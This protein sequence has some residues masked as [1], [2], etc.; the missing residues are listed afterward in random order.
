V[1]GDGDSKLKII[2]IDTGDIQSVS[3]GR[4]HR[5]DEMA[6]EPTTDILVA[7]NDREGGSANFLT[8]FKAHPLSIVGKIPCPQWVG[9]IEQPVVIGGR[10]YVAFPG[11]TANPKGE[12]DLINPSTLKLDQVIKAGDCA[13]TGLAAGINGLFV[14]GGGA[15]VVEPRTGTGT[16]I[17]DAGGDE[18]ATLPGRGIYAFVIAATQTLN[19]ADAGTNQVY[20][21]LPVNLGHNLAANQDTG[22][23]WIPDY[24]TEIGVGLRTCDFTGRRHKIAIWSSLLG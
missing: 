7:A 17:A 8:V 13:P 3:T 18:I 19:L 1:G 21:T 15:C 20:Q 23:I 9:D 24:Q 6:Y 16:P 14:T 10:F 11:T 22:E 12:I 5:V 4:T 2:N